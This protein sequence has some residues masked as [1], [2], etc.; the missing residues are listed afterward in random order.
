MIQGDLRLEHQDNALIVRS[1]HNARWYGALGVGIALIFLIQWTSVPAPSG[2]ALLAYWFG[3]VI[4]VVA[5]AGIG[6]FLLL[7]RE[8]ITTFDLRCH[9][10]VHHVSIGRGWYER[11]RT[12]AFTEIA[13]LRLN[14]YDPEP[15]S[16]HAS[17]D[18]AEW[19]DAVAQHGKQQL[20]DLR[21]DNRGDLRSN[22][23]AEARRRPAALVGKLGGTFLCAKRRQLEGA[24]TRSSTSRDR[25]SAR[26]LRASHFVCQRRRGDTIAPDRCCRSR[27]GVRCWL[28]G[29]HEC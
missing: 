5:P 25:E 9:R 16:L 17:H 6:V 22:W 26:P 12:Y 1:K 24:S 19:R 13:G 7:P 27:R 4:G 2:L 14:G 23:I 10:V 8:V 29:G 15:D 11:R 18:P 21:N 3:L 28:A 20:S